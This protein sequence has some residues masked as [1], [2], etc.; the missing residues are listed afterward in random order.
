MARHV[1]KMTETP[2]EQD[3]GS[4]NA[5]PTTASEPPLCDSAPTIIESDPH[6]NTR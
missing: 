1:G 5:L 4:L 6:G 3:S 2:S